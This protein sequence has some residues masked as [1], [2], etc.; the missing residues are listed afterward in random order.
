MFRL[1]DFFPTTGAPA[2]AEHYAAA[3]ARCR[4]TRDALREFSDLEL[5]EH[6][7]ALREAVRRERRKF[8]TESVALIAEAVRRAHGLAAYDVQLLAGLALADGRL[9]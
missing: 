5:R 2:A 3:L 6:G 1:H 9:G 8:H 4:E 7:A